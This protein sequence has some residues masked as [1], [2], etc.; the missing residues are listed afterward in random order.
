MF[1]VFLIKGLLVLTP[2][3]I[4]LF[5]AI[6]YTLGGLIGQKIFNPSKE[7]LYRRI[8]YVLIALSALMGLP[9]WS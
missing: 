9:I 1:I 3:I 8:A 4:G 2:L 5:L 7:T 6:P